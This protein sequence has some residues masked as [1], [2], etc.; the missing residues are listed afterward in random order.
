MVAQVL[1]LP[2]WG[3]H[4]HAAQVTDGPWERPARVPQKSFIDSCEKVVEGFVH[5]SLLGSG[6]GCAG[7]HLCGE[8]SLEKLCKGSGM[9]LRVAAVVAMMGC[10]ALAMVAPSARAGAPKGLERTR[11]VR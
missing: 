1:F 8:E 11:G 7:E 9:S 5:V 2:R 10:V 6:K 3:S 4:S